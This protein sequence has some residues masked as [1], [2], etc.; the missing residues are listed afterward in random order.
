MKR[1]WL[2]FWVDLAMFAAM[3]AAAGIGLVLKYVLPPGSGG[4]R[5]FRG[6][7]G[8]SD[9]PGA[10]GALLLLGLT[11][12]EWGDIHF[13]VSLVL[14]ALLAAHIVLHWT[15]IK[16]RLKALLKTGDEGSARDKGADC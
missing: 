12:H 8:L 2:N 15:W 5:G 13:Y 14:V 1:V 11:R 7:R 6:G 9:G 4:G 16:C 3:A 10:D